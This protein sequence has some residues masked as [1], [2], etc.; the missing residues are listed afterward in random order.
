[1]AHQRKESRRD[2]LTVSV[3]ECRVRLQTGQAT[4]FIDARKEADRAASNLQIAGSIRFA[5]DDRRWR[6]PCHQRNYVVVY[7]G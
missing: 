7:C 1:M 2:T 4:F 3:D 6:P 5:F